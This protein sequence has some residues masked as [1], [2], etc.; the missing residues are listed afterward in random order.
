MRGIDGRIGRKEFQKLTATDLMEREVTYYPKETNCYTLAL[1]IVQGN[2]GSIPI[3]DDEK[4]LI[5]VVSEFDLLEALLAGMDLD[6]LTAWEIMKHPF[7]VSEEMPGREIMAFLQK[8]RLIRAPV[9][10]RSGRLV[11]IVAR[12]D[13]L[14]GYIKT[15]AGPRLRSTG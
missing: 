11:G 14:A 13:L 4:R 6:H 7:S 5:G 1:G 9:T 2:F 10:D 8:N 12:R 15:K 3:V